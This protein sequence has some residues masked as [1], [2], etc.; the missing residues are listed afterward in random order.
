MQS[1]RPFSSD[2]ALSGFDDC[3]NK[4]GVQGDSTCPKLQEHA[5]CR[6]CPV[7]A[8]AAILLLDRDTPK[9]YGSEWSSPTVRAKEGADETG[10]SFAIFRVGLEWLALPGG[11]FV[12]VAELKTT[13]S[14][15][16]RRNRAVRGLANFRGELLVC[17][18]LETVL[19]IDLVEKQKTASRA[20]RPRLLVIAHH[21]RRL[22]FAVDEVDGIHRF[23][24]RDIMETP[25][26]VTRTGSAYSKGILKHKGHSVGL[27][28]SDL[29]LQTLERSLG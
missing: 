23:Y 20:A 22:G 9:D 29:L 12:A 16:H 26:T 17:V 14:I 18:S 19:K 1:E 28:D 13:H 6:N 7:Y 21:G 3:W 5:H 24:L 25:A 2:A 15:P 11:I 4:I 10:Q 8:A 27:L